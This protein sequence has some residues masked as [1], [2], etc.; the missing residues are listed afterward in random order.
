MVPGLPGAALPQRGV[1]AS[2][3]GRLCRVGIGGCFLGMVL[4]G[5][6]VE[7]ACAA[8]RDCLREIERAQADTRSLRA[9]FVQTK[10][11]S[12]LGE[13]IVSRGLFVFAKPDRVLWEIEEPQPL[14][15]LITGGE[16]RLD[17][18]S[19]RDSSML[20]VSPL[21]TMLSQLGSIFA[22]EVEALEAGF[23]VVAADAGGRIELTL[24]PRREDWKRMFRVVRLQFERPL[25]AVRRIELE[26]ALGDRLEIELSAVERNVDVAD[27]M[28]EGR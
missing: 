17:G 23:D 3:A 20:A 9:R 10:H 24:T 21:S 26:D 11:L 27:S 28:L 2:L 13:P 15:V 12:L 6:P 4:L 14:R 19:Q 18:V 8:A 5:S 25:L 1:R 7:A 22:G 16:V